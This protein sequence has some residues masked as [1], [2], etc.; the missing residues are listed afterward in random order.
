MYICIIPLH[1]YIFFPNPN[2]FF[3]L[4]STAFRD[5]AQGNPQPHHNNCNQGAQN[6][7]SGI[8]EDGNRF[9]ER[10]DI[11]VPFDLE[12][13]GCCFGYLRERNYEEVR[14]ALF[15]RVCFS[16]ENF[17]ETGAII[18]S[19]MVNSFAKAPR[20][21]N[22]RGQVSTGYDYNLGERTARTFGNSR[23]YQL[24][25]QT[26]NLSVGFLAH[27]RMESVAIDVVRG[28]ELINIYL[29][30]ADAALVELYREGRNLP[31]LSQAEVTGYLLL[32]NP[33]SNN[34]KAKE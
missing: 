3:L 28:D 31:S 16:S 12:C 29:N 25:S 13:T 15:D 21:R 9:I 27:A 30:Y 11:Q 26:G 6:R 32:R 34:Q 7:H 4:N 14:G 17:A 18:P 1:V 5:M 10:Y 8:T 23:T 19:D 22:F 33:D 20:R 24:Y 2:N